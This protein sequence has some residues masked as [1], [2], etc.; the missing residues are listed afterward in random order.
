LLASALRGNDS[1]NGELMSE[2]LKASLFRM[3]IHLVAI[4]T[5]RELHDRNNTWR[6]DV[7]CVAEIW[8][9]DVE[10]PVW[11]TEVRTVSRHILKAEPTPF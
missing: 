1:A 3:G 8:A 4:A 9:S 5:Q 2:C 6:R 7:R 11:N 10:G